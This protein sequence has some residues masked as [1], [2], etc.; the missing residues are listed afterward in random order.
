MNSARISPL[1]EA[2]VHFLMYTN[3]T[4]PTTRL[5][6]LLFELVLGQGTD[7]P[8]LLFHCF[9]VPMHLTVIGSYK[10]GLLSVRSLGILVS[11]IAINVLLLLGFAFEPQLSSA[12]QMASF[13]IC[14]FVQ[15]SCVESNLW[16]A[17]FCIKPIV[18]VS[19]L[20]LA[21]GQLYLKQWHDI[22]V[23]M[24]LLLFGCVS[25]MGF[26]SSENFKKELMQSLNETKQQLTAILSAVPVG[27]FVLTSKGDLNS[28][29]AFCL[30]LLGCNS[31]EEAHVRVTQLTYKAGTSRY[32]DSLYLIRDLLHY[33]NSESNDTADFGQTEDDDRVLSWIGQK[34]IWHGQAAA[35][36]VIKDVTEVL[37]LER[38]K[39]ESQFKNVMLRSVSHELKT[40]TNGIMHSVQAVSE[41]ED[42]PQWA[43]TK[44]EIANVSCKHLL[45]LIS[46]LLDFSQIVSGVFRL[47]S[48]FFDL[49]KVLGDCVDLVSMIAAKKNISVVRLLDP[50]LPEIVY[51]DQNRLSQ[52]I[53]NLL[54]NSIKF[55]PSG[56]KIIFRALLTD[57]GQMEISVEDNGVGIAEAEFDRL[58][59][60]F[61]RLDYASGMNPQGVGL[62]LY[63]SNALSH[64]LGGE[65][66]KVQSRLNKGSCFSFKSNI[67]QIGNRRV[68]SCYNDYDTT[69][70]EGCEAKPIYHFRLKTT[71]FPPVLVVDDSPINRMVIVE[72]L[73]TL[74]IKCAEAENGAE[75]V[76]YVIKRAQ[77]GHPLKVVVMDFEMPVMNGPTASKVLLK[78]LIDLNLPVP[79]VIAH[80]AYTSEEDMRL[81]R[82][83]GMVDYLPKPSSCDTVISIVTKYIH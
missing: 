27:I 41:G 77:E 24:A 42:V 52:I 13:Y 71:E 54:S 6:M 45:M 67:L 30:N 20:G 1:Q 18:S 19:I 26:I 80:S 40:P 29:N 65:P 61:G 39:V 12:W 72:I 83:A 37:Q 56:G 28:P 79:K 60:I 51:L 69:T 31:A 33:L 8:L 7:F 14:F 2:L 59:T 58:F 34:T 25:V 36:V 49:R 43:K 73:A 3:A 81:C 10:L 70:D 35:V 68:E 55:T 46:D 64:K 62:G 9:L 48:S 22:I 66:I 50:L 17:L 57:D 32:S 78:R 53:L 75:A 76:E 5:V 16:K 21:T 4:L 82:D 47:S 11:E 23:I 63:I 74:Q 38:T 15:V 44:L